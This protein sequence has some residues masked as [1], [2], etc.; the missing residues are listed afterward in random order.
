MPS[1]RVTLESENESFN[2]ICKARNNFMGSAMQTKRE[3]SRSTSGK[4]IKTRIQFNH[5]QLEEASV[6]QSWKYEPE[7][8]AL[9]LS[10]QAKWTRGLI[11]VMKLRNV[12]FQIYQ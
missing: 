12:A 3:H 5:I 6:L 9:F 1:I 7:Q 10:M 11:T 4:R 2:T 8:I